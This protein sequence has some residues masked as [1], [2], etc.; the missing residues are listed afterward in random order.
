MLR[1]RGA[2]VVAASSG[3][4]ALEAASR[5]PFSFVLL[6]LQM[7][8][9]DGYQVLRRLRALPAGEA[10]PV[11]AL[12]ALTSEDVRRRCEAEGVNDFVTKPVTLARIRELVDRWGGTSAVALQRPQ[13]DR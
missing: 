2:E 6:D 13:A 12:T 3:R 4:E 1:S 11:V 8:E 7:P 10:L 5:Q 9:I